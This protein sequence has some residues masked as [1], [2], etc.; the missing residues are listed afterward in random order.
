MVKNI[1]TTNIVE[2]CRKALPLIESIVNKKAEGITGVTKDGEEWKVVVEVLERKA[3]P[4]T[5]D[6]LNIYELKLTAD[7]ELTGYKRIGMRHRGDMMQD[8]EV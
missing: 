1:K 4:D 5:Q 8:E 7:L 2:I 3:I 6:I